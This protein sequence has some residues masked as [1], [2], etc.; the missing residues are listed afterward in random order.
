MNI[1][2][3][4]SNVEVNNPKGI[5]NSLFKIR[6]SIFFSLCFITFNCS[7]QQDPQFSMFMFDKMALDPA[8]AG[9]KDALEV[10]LMSRDQ[11]LDIPGAPVTNALTVSGASPGKNAGWGIEVMDD[12]I[13]P[14]TSNTVQGNY[15]YNIRIGNGKLAMGLGLGVYDYA[16]DLSKIDY[17]DKNDM[18]AMANASSKFTPTA[19]AGLYYYTTSYY[20]GFSVN[21]LIESQVTDVTVDNS[22]ITTVPHAYFIAGK[23]F[24]SASGIIWNPSV[25]LQYAQNAPPSASINLNVLLAEKLW[26]GASYQMQYG[27]VF[28]IAYKASHT[29]SIGYAYDLGLNAIGVV[30]GGT[31]ELTLTLD[32]GSNKA[33]Q[34]SPRF[35]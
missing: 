31:H 11:W 17:R 7:A 26:L 12:Q 16:F 28:L 33:S 20:I 2:H 25:I 35:F 32:F 3:G 1:E 19:D 6:Y 9:S 27:C 10:N 30:G 8:A 18:S 34:V 24:E 23:A 15:A 13:G 29:L 4:I 14:T 21:H 5:R 22:S